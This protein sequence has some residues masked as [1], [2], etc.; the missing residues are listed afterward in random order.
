MTDYPP[1]VPDPFDY[2]GNSVGV[3]LIH[4]FTGSPSEVLPM[5]K[6]LAKQGYTVVGPL[7]PGHGTTWQ[8]MAHRKWQEWADA[9]EQAYLGLKSR[10]RIVFVSGG[11]MGGLLT[12]YLAAR[13]PEIAGI[14]PMAPAIF[15]VDWRASFAWLLKYFIPFKPYDPA[16]DGD[17][18]TDPQARQRYLWSYMGSPV[19]AGEQLVL[20]QRAVRRDLHKI[21][22]PTLIFQG[23]RDQSVKLESAVYAFS[24]VAARDKELTWLTNSGHCLWVDSEKEQVWQKTYQ[25]IAARSAS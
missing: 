14:I 21:A 20:L 22:M 25:F 4:G 2:P 3:L 24:H 18:L 23:T 12:L 10:C 19:A 7:L 8:D 13:H 9:T 1:P 6:Y 17:D 16:R 15:T 5:G 11:S